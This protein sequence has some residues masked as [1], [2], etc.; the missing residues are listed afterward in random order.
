MRVSS[1]S[2]TTCTLFLLFFSARAFSLV[3][4]PVE[5]FAFRLFFSKASWDETLGVLRG[6][7]E[8]GREVLA[9][10][11]VGGLM[12]SDSGTRRRPIGSLF[13]VVRFC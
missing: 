8:R 9:G 5:V 10:G 11:A 3:F 2:A 7:G 1:P 6:L 12:S 13:V 4:G